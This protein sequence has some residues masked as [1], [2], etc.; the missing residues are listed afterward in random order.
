MK[1]NAEE[2][3]LSSHGEICFNR[4][5][6]VLGEHILHMLS[7]C[8]HA[9]FSTAVLGNVQMSQSDITDNIMA[10]ASQISAGVDGGARNIKQLGIKTK[11][12]LSIPIYMSEGIQIE[13]V[14][15]QFRFYNNHWFFIYSC[16]LFC[17]F[18]C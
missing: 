1:L 8:Y 10:A 11:Q 12:S 3:D 18:S 6:C 5:A 13:F 9:Y 15:S 4:P 2:T 17:K 7:Y 14:G 16:F